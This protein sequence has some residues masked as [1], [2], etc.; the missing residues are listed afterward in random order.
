MHRFD[1]AVIPIHHSSGQP[2]ATG[3][4]GLCRRERAPHSGSIARTF[5]RAAR[6]AAK[7]AFVPFTG[8]PKVSIAQSI[9]PGA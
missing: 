8:R 4:A 5:R 9:L 2:S 1:E 3:E 7:A 6:L